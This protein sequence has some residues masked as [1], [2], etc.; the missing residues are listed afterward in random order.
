MPWVRSLIAVLLLLI[1]A[2][3][4]AAAQGE[5]PPPA[6]PP[7]AV[8]AAQPDSDLQVVIEEPDFTLGA[9]PTTLRMPA[10]KFAFRLTHRFNRPIAEGERD[11]DLGEGARAPRREALRAPP[12]HLEVYDP[13]S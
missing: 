3:R 11:G 2:A 10:R 12:P 5:A 8:P 1:A 9:L 13:A 4:P 7:P 6:P